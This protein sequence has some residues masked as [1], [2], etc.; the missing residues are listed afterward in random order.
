MAD[1]VL[2]PPAPFLALPGEPPIPWTHWLQS[3]ET[4]ILVVG[5]TDVCAAR[6]KALLLHCL[7]AEGQRV[8]GTLESGT[9]NNY[10]T[11]VE[12][13]FAHFAAPQSVLLRRFLFRQRLQLPGESVQQ[14]VANLQG[15]ASTCK[16]GA[17][18]EEM[19]RD[20]LIEHTNN[21]KPSQNDTLAAADSSAV[22]LLRRQQRSRPCPQTQA[23]RPCDYCGSSSH[24]RQG[25]LQ[26]P[27]H[28]SSRNL[29]AFVTHAGVF[30][31]MCMPFGLSS[32]PSCFQKIMVSVLA[33]ILGVAIYLECLQSC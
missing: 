19:I 23:S 10:D 12:L 5:L 26:V 13:L 8:L 2:P 4:F 25:Y 22:M 9:T 20:Q 14:Y 3:F 21:A 16:F 32:A 7:G 27:L 28:P 33:G 6:K 11:A 29:T 24:L 30:L 31:Y 1:I 18:Q 17:L 15:L